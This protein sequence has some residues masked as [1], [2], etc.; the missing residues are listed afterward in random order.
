MKVYQYEFTEGVHESA[1]SDKCVRFIK[2]SELKSSIVDLINN[3]S[4]YS[5]Y[6]NELGEIVAQDIWGDVHQA[7]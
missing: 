4:L 5:L 1:S 2:H 7:T 6:Y 3:G